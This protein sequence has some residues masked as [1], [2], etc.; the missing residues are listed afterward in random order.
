MPDDR[1]VIL[2][3]KW[4][5]RFCSGTENVDDWLC[6]VCDVAEL[7]KIRQDSRVELVWCDQR[8]DGC[9]CGARDLKV[10]GWEHDDW[11]RV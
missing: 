11:R 4:H 2:L 1:R 8:R 10:S 3:C 6:P 7:E 9:D 5:M